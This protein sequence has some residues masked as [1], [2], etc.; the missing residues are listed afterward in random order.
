MNM[1]VKDEWREWH[2]VT[3]ME[4]ALLQ[5]LVPESSPDRTCLLSQGRAAKC[6]W[7]ESRGQPALLFASAGERCTDPISGVVGEGVANDQDG[8]RIHFLL[9]VQDGML[10][11]I[12]V[13]REDGDA[14]IVFPS[15]TVIEVE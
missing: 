9:H 2:S 6:R 11:E 15:P 8:V 14:V 4:T 12:E 1:R 10:K 5:R 3:D 7:L 13:Y